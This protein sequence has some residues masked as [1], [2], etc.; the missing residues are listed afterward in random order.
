M[1]D[2]NFD[3]TTDTK[4][5]WENYWD[6]NDSLGGGGSDPDAVSPTLQEYHRQLWSKQLPN[7]ETMELKKGYGANYLTW[8]DFR[9]GSD[10]I[11]VSFR[12][13]KYRYM[14]EKV[15]QKVP[16]YKAF[17]EKHTR[18]SYTIGGFIIF[19]RHR[20]SI[21]QNKG[22][23]VLVSDRWD[24]TLECIRR[25]YN[26]ENSPL[27]SILMTDKEFFDLFVDF[28]GY[29]DF[30]LLQDAVSDDYSKVKIWCGNT[31]F[32][33]S[34]LPKTVEEYF[35]FIELEYDFLGKRNKRIKNYSDRYL[36]DEKQSGT[37]DC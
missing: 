10:S 21:N 33:D 5:Y 26:G 28:K 2:T 1:I 8:K 22:T 24:L 32:A 16:D 27:Y 12:Y 18:K 25:Y 3:F 23:N 7:G 36:C 19:P 6:R 15:K 13:K 37:G 9:F 17:Y 34:G 14:I 31:E 11:I 30:F 35:Q 4:G 20:N 29:V